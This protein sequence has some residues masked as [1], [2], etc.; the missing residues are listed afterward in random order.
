MGRSAEILQSH[1][2]KK[3]GIR[4][5]VI[6]MLDKM[7]YAVSQPEL[8]SHLSDEADRV[9]I[10]RTLN[11]LEEKGIVHKVIDREGLSRF[12][13]CSSG[14]S[15]HKH[16]DEHLHFQCTSCSNIYCLSIPVEAQFNLPQGFEIHQMRIY[17]DGICKTCN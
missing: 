16:H 12:A 4:I 14:C 7:P 2:L 9:T 10:Y 3:T 6:E 8:E 11:T 17:V 15:E 1:G 13:M 5:K